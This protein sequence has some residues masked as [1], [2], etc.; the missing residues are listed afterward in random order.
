MG[1]ETDEN[2]A[3]ELQRQPVS[4]DSTAPVVKERRQ[5]EDLEGR[6]V[7]LG[8]N[9][10]A[11]SRELI[12]VMDLAPLPVSTVAP[13]AATV[14]PTPAAV[15]ALTSHTTPHSTLVGAPDHPVQG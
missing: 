3:L 5:G 6:R 14:A 8:D 12:P 11:L 9:V 15:P 1:I 7:N 4:V 13:V 10:R 2:E